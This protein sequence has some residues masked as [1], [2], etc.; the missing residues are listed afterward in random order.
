LLAEI[1]TALIASPGGIKGTVVC[2]DLKGN[3][4]EL[5][6]DAYKYMKDFIIKV[7]SEPDAKV[8]K[9]ALTG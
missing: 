5:M 8:G 7:F 6:K 3:H 1:S 2:Q 9:S 4:L